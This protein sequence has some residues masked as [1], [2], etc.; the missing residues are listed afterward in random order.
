MTGFDTK[1][2][3]MS[4]FEIYGNF[5]LSHGKIFIQDV[6]ETAKIAA[7]AYAAPFEIKSGR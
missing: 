5:I 3:D 4:K 2:H 7:R 6:V 1:K